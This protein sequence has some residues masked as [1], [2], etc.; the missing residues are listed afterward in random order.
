[1]PSCSPPARA[2]RE[3]VPRRWIVHSCL[4]LLLS[5]GAEQRSDDIEDDLCSLAQALRHVE[6]GNN[7]I[8]VAVGHRVIAGPIGGERDN[9]AGGPAPL[10]SVVVE[11]T[12]PADQLGRTK[13]IGKKI[14]GTD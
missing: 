3:R 6:I 11:R 13:L 7:G 5:F 10:I 14:A 4:Q 8:G 9:F 12:E 1:M 2:L